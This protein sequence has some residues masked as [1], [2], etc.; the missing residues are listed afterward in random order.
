MSYSTIVSLAKGF[1][2]R[3]QREKETLGHK[4]LLPTS[5]LHRGLSCSV[6]SGG[7]N[8]QEVVH[9]AVPEGGGGV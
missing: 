5:D 6:P 7:R 4:V 1:L 3:E 2:E 9:L 8:L